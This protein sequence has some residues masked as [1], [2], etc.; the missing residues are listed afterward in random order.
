MLKNV[1]YLYRRAGILGEE[2]QSA[3]EPIREADFLDL[4]CLISWRDITMFSVRRATYRWGR[5]TWSSECS[6]QIGKEKTSQIG[7]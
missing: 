3:H 5:G 1:S 4:L 7:K 2:A 6:S